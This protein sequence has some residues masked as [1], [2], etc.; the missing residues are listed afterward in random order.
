MKIVAVIVTYNRLALLKKCLK[1]VSG[2]TRKPDEIIVINNGSTDNTEEWLAEQNVITFTQEN[3]GGAGGFSSGINQA[4]RHH[5][6]WI[7]LMDDD[8][9]PQANSLEKLVNAFNK[10]EYQKEQVGFL[11]SLVLWTN[12]S[13][14]ELNR[15]FILKDKKKIAKFP[16]VH[17]IDMPLIQWGTFVSMLLSEKAVEKVGLPIKDF[18]IWCDDAEYSKRII[19]SGMP[20]FL[21]EDSIVI[22]E[23]PSN[24]QSS[25]LKDPQSAI[26][27]YNYGL[28]NELYSKRMHQGILQ[29]WITWTHRM[30]IMPIR[31]VINRKNHRWPFI[32]VVWK[33]SLRALFFRPTIEKADNVHLVYDIKMSNRVASL[34]N[35]VKST[36]H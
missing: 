16:F 12:G 11:S 9:I 4:Y 33:T 8:T 29:F 21:V 22:H 32:K 23:T 26:W 3:N 13:H 15:T 30:F 20:G 31:I 24:H 19:G 35:P 25:V 17:Q 34:D 36:T 1:A 7:W 14:H 5:A 6:D 27:K 28:R 18:F 2:Q 10:I